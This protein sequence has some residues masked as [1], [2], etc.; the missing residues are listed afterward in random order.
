[1]TLPSYSTNYS[2]RPTPG[3]CWVCLRPGSVPADRR[4]RVPELCGLACEIGWVEMYSL[5]SPATHTVQGEAWAPLPAAA[6]AP[7]VPL[8]D[9]IEVEP[10]PARIAKPGT[11]LNN[12]RARWAQ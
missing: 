9:D 12:L 1:M 7:A 2:R 6:A 10:V 5:D 8:A 3:Q 4:G 11:W